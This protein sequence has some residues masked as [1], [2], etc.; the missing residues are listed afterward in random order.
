MELINIK[1]QICNLDCWPKT[2]VKYE[3]R[4][5]YEKKE[6]KPQN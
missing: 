3:K 5:K 2:A 4:E 1:L 6:K